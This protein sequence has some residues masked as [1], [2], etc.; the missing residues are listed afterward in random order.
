MF[1]YSSLEGLYDEFLSALL[2]ELYQSLSS[3]LGGEIK[4]LSSHQR[5]NKDLFVR[6]EAIIGR[7]GPD[8]RAART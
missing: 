2:Q 1:G 8:F 6:D 7:T 3:N 5:T 4:I